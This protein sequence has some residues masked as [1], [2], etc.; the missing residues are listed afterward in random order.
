[1]GAFPSNI[2]LLPAASRLD[3]ESSEAQTSRLD[4]DA[5]QRL[6]RGEISALGEIYDRHHL[7]VRRFVVRMTGSTHDAE[8]LVHTTF[9]TVAK[10]A[11]SFDPSRSCRAWLLGIA[12]R[13]TR[14]QRTAN[15]RLARAHSRLRQALPFS[16]IDP[17]RAIDA[18][19]DLQRIEKVLAAMS[20]KE[21]VTFIM[22]DVEGLRCDEVAA[23]LEVPIGTVWRRLHDARRKLLA[24][25][26][27]GP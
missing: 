5:M 17:E 18:R 21:R 8:D 26:P 4:A 20:K 16:S 10:V 15:A 3:E 6:C 27:G 11:A 19:S 2:L 13:V 12:V 7:G 24:R 1:M 22:V 14:R 9:L 23:A 25:V